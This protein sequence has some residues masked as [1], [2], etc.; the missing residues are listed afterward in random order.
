MK[1][2]IVQTSFLGDTIL[3]TPVISGL[4]T[5]YPNAELWMMTTPLS[6]S[7]I[8]RD[9]FLTGVIT[10]DKKSSDSGIIGLLRVRTK[11][12]SMNFERV[13]SLHRSY[14]TSILLALSGIPERIGFDNAKLSFIYHQTYKRQ[15]EDH[16]VF[17][18]LSILSGEV[19][20][21][22]L[23]TDLRLFSPGKDELS[24]DI[25]EKMPVSGKYAV[26]VPGSV[27][28]TKRWSLEGYR[29]VARYLMNKGI[30]IVLMGAESDRGVNGR[31]SDGLSV[32][33]L[34]GQTTIDD[35]MYIMEH[36]R[37]AICNDSMSLHMASAFKV[38]TIAIF[39]ATSPEQGF[40][41]WKNNAVV[42]QKELSCRPCSR[43]GTIK[44][45]NGSEACMN[46]LAHE[47]VIAA[48]EEL[49]NPG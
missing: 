34:T 13:Y 29:E 23:D 7:L 22:N 36:A 33:D 12:K 8:K 9:P 16:D 31:I 4:K 24:G 38:P 30:S 37:L 20:L 11:I 43:H 27:W 2:L 1:I 45:P 48:I 35:A 14:R 46:D 39:C 32:S 44:C 40:G 17:R 3:S 10:D 21:K 18:N 26:L 25:S 42:V 5:L 49:M 19:S 15:N 41:P 47:E 6:S 28:P